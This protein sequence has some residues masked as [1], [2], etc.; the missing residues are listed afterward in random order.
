MPILGL[1]KTAEVIIRKAKAADAA[2]LAELFKSSW[3]VAYRGIIPHFHLETIIHNRA[4]PWWKRLISVGDNLLVMEL[5]DELAG[6]TTYGRSRWPLKPEGEV[7]EL[8]LGPIYQ[9]IGLGE[10]L[11]EA[12]R[13]RLEIR[14]LRGLLIWALKDN[15]GAC[16]FYHRRGGRPIARTHER[17]GRQRIEKI[18][19]GF[20]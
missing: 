10:H 7:Y 1:M 19:F 15:L 20:G 17:F 3:H 6:Y 12:A 5:G 18:A 16:D 2:A 9:G 8:Y 13:H 4:E 14:R 11:F